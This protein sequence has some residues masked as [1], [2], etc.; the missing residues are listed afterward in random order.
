MSTI[1]KSSFRSLARVSL[2]L[3]FAFGLLAVTQ[4]ATA[5]RIFTLPDIVVNADGVTATPGQIVASVEVTG[6]DIGEDT[7]S[8]YNIN[9]DVD[10]GVTLT[11][12]S[13]DAPGVYSF[14]NF[15]DFTGGQ[16]VG[17]SDDGGALS[18]VSGDLA[19]IDFEIPAGVTS[20]VFPLTWLKQSAFNNYNDASGAELPITFLSGS[21]TVVPEPSS[22]AL[23]LLACSVLVFFRK[24]Q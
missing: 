14:G 6:A 8:S 18:A 24:R 5:S 22:V 20:G 11:S 23:G 7:I 10:S 1:S 2:T 3:T 13:M 17:S 19:L 9:F 21:I 4:T 15:T 16:T 12:A